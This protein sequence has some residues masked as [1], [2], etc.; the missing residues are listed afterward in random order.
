ME[1]EIEREQGEIL[2]VSPGR[3][4]AGALESQLAPDGLS[5]RRMDGYCAPSEDLHGWHPVLIVVDLQPPAATWLEQCWEVR[6]AS[7]AALIAILPWS[8]SDL[9]TAILN[10]GADDCLARPIS[11][12]E[13]TLRIRAVL[14]RMTYVRL[15][16]VLPSKQGQD[17][18]TARQTGSVPRCGTVTRRRRS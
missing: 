13:L 15:P 6:S 1:V 8:D 10:L 18:D 2:V 16:K 11:S 4:L 7:R 17:S 5:L 3:E 14:R 9:A 12:R